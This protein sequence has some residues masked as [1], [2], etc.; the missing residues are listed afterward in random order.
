MRL[1]EAFRIQ[2]PI[3][4]ALVGAGGKSTTLFTLARELNPPVILTTSTH[5]AKAEAGLADRHIVF[6]P[7]SSLEEVKP[8]LSKGITLFTGNL[9]D[10]DNRT[11]GL[12][13]EE[14]EQIF[15]IAEEMHCH[16]LVEADG[17][18]RLSV[19]APAAHEPPIPPWANT[20]GVTVGLSCLGEPVTPEH[21]FR[22][23]LFLE[24]SGLEYGGAL[25]PDGLVKVLA[26]PEGGLKNIPPFAKRVAI[27]NQADTPELQ[28]IAALM[29]E[30]LVA[31]FDAVLINSYQAATAEPGSVHAVHEKIAGLI[32]A[33]GG[34]KRYG[35]PKAL[36]DWKRKPFV[37]HVAERALQA[38]LN[39]VYMVLGAVIGPIREALAG[40]PVQ[41]VMNEDW[42]QGQSTSVA[43]GIASLPERVGGAV[44]LMAD[45]PQVPSELI[46]S[47]VK[48][49]SR[50][51]API[52]TPVVEGR[53]SSPVLMDQKMFGDLEM[54]QGDMGGRAIFGNYPLL[55][56]PWDNPDD[57][58]D[59]D[60]P[61]DYQRLLSL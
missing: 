5:L 20:V 47:L 1:K 22:A 16:L 58:F 12:E 30:K 25:T 24:L 42:E 60:T 52:I 35:V 31:V 7:N 38:G 57:L 13:A 14:L 44:M 8:L 15:L 54:L 56:F 51:L 23:N 43:R 11:A 37:R 17:S 29:A 49:H 53:R 2:D 26:H 10:Q 48:M 19:K 4:L 27:L 61:E 36:L 9:I 6:D 45:Q 32:L 39:P 34:S 21:V 28:E 50:T 59:V 46:R 33:G 18:R 41:F 40:L 3:R 55:K